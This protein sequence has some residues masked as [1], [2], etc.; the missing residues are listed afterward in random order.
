MNMNTR[1]VFSALP[2][3]VALIPV[4]VAC[5]GT[6]DATFE[7]KAATSDQAL[8]PSTSAVSYQKKGGGLS[9]IGPDYNGTTSGT[10]MPG[11]SSSIAEMDGGNYREAYQGKDGYLWLNYFGLANQYLGMD[12]ASSP[13]IT[14]LI[15]G[16]YQVAFQ[17]NTHDLYVAG[18]AGTGD[19]GYGMMPGTSPS[20]AAMPGGSWLAAMQANVGYLWIVGPGIVLPWVAQMA[21][22]TNPSIA[23]RSDGT[24]QV[25]FQG[26]DSYLR[27]YDSQSGVTNTWYGMA[28]NTSPSVSAVPSGGYEIAFQ[29]NTG[30]LWITG[31]LGAGDVGLGM[32]AGT[33]P[34]ITALPGGGWEATFQANTGNLWVTGSQ[35]TNDTSYAMAPKT[36]P[37]ICPVYP[38][39]S[40]V[41]ASAP[42]LGTTFDLQVN[43]KA[44]AGASKYIVK[45][46]YSDGYVQIPPNGSLTKTVTSTSVDWNENFFGNSHTYGFTVQACYPNGFCGKTSSEVR[47]KT[48]AKSGG[49]GTGGNT[50]TVGVYYYM[51]QS[52]NLNCGSSTMKGSLTPGSFASN[53]STGALTGQSNCPGMGSGS[54]CCAF[55]L[56]ASGLGAGNYTMTVNAPQCSET[57]T[58]SLAT[59][60]SSKQFSGYGVTCPK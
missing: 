50:G 54:N 52:S 10:M 42:P 17:A 19:Q 45:N 35:L 44:V 59:N 36:S 27:T 43:W 39:P 25:A 26:L 41:S 5:S 21:P 46:T 31:P 6:T 14:G 20:I 34:S 16:G 1:S 4:S 12:N 15:G 3:L 2:L 11:T 55:Y 40:G 18:T 22:N 33:S 29:A 32:M 38:V 58:F 60:S 7:Q 49:G 13:S 8:S 24:W 51:A 47:A 9:D 53:S 28:P 57:V 30:S 56:G 48:P 23:T 37:S